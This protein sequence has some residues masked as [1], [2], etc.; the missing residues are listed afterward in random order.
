VSLLLLRLWLL[1]CMLLSCTSIQRQACTSCLLLLHAALHAG[2]VLL[3][4]A[5]IC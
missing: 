5:R 3:C 4:S 1:L 2:R